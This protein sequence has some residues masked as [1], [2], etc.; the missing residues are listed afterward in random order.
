MERVMFFQ[1]EGLEVLQEPYAPIFA[2]VDVLED[3]KRISSVRC[4]DDRLPLI[5]AHKDTTGLAPDLERLF[6]FF[7]DRDDLSTDALPFVGCD[8]QDGRT[9]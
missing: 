9:C 5:V 6:E 3:L 7:R 2:G 4:L 1:E 8:M